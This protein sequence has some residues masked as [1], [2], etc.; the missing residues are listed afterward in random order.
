MDGADVVALVLLGYFHFGQIDDDV[1]FLRL[2]SQA[3]K[4]DQ[5]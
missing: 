3:A 2:E 5:E 4:R 1:S